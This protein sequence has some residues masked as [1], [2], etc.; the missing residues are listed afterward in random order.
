MSEIDVSSGTST[1]VDATLVVGAEP[2]GTADIGAMDY[3]VVS[4][5]GDA[6]PWLDVAYGARSGGPDALIC[7]GE[8][9]RSTTVASSS[10]VGQGGI[11]VSAVPDVGSLGRMAAELRGAIETRERS[12]DSVGIVLTGFDAAIETTSV[13]VAFRFL[14]VLRGFM[15]ALE[16]DSAIYVYTSDTL[17]E[18]DIETLRPLFTT[19]RVTES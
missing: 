17:T 4:V 9:L 7:A 6:E 10:G 11:S 3:Q 2:P 13:E 8:M 12:S 1:T 19:V 14:H 5:F 16:A 15:Q 18:E